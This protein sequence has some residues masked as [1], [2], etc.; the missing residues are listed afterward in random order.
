MTNGRAGDLRAS[1][2][3]LIRHFGPASGASAAADPDLWCVYLMRPLNRTKC[4]P[5][6]SCLPCRSPQYIKLQK[7][8]QEHNRGLGVGAI[9]KF[10]NISM[11]LHFNWAHKRFKVAR[12]N[13]PRGHKLSPLEYGYIQSRR[14][15]LSL[16]VFI[17]TYFRPS[18]I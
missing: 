5:E 6:A 17:Y 12:A 15:S 9:I 11:R 16:C 8:E 10:Y 18:T 2:M 1:L 3:P 14:D 4:L 13:F 7:H